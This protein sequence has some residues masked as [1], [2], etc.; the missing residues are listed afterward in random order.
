MIVHLFIPCFVDQLYPTVG[1]NMVKVLEKAG[2][3]VHYN[4]N[5]TCCGQPAFNAGYWGESK[6]VCNK[7][8]TDF[9]DAEYVVMPS[10][11]CTGFVE[12]NTANYLKIPLICNR[13]KKSRPAFL[14]SLNS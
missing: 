8:I 2:C 1:F 14:N 9:N 11:S 6:E 7:F 12:M 10:A 5:Q 4:P 13:H 3:E